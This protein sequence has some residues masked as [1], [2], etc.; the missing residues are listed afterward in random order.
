MEPA[1]VLVCVV[2]AYG[3]ADL[4][5][6][7]DHG[8]KTRHPTNCRVTRLNILRRYRGLFVKLILFVSEQPCDALA[9][10]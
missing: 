5:I 8:T 3:E 7:A 1:E 9:F 6:Q 4:L 10:R 2:S